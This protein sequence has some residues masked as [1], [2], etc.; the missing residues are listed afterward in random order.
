M[1]DT[2]PG[3][4]DLLI[5][6]MSVLLPTDLMI[7]TGCPNIAADGTPQ[8]CMTVQWTGYVGTYEDTPV[9]TQESLGICLDGG[10]V[11]LGP[12]MIAAAGQTEVSA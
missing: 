4:S 3:R 10:S 9:L 2:A 6:G 11:P 7:V 8:P 12:V 1:T 5:E